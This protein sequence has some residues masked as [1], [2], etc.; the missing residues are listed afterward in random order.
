MAKEYAEIKESHVRFIGEYKDTLPVFHTD[1]GITVRDVTGLGVK[2]GDEH[3]G[4]DTYVTPEAVVEEKTQ[5]QKE[6]DFEAQKSALLDEAVN[7]SQIVQAMGQTDASLQTYVQN[8]DAM[9]YSE[10][11]TWPVKPF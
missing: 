3:K 6:S 5:V 8:L 9:T 7:R 2:E 1:S 4:G 11:P 10:N